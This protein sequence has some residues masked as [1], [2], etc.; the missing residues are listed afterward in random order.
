MK[1]GSF[2]NK[3]H[4]HVEKSSHGKFIKSI[5]Y[6]GLDG[7]ITTFA[8]VSG[9][10]G[11]HLDSSIVLI[12]GVANLLADGLSMGFGDY[13]SSEAE[14]EYREREKK[15]AEDVFEYHR[16][17]ELTKIKQQYQE[18]GMSKGDAEKMAQVLSN[19]KHC[20]VETFLKDRGMVKSNGSS[21][22]K[23]LYT[24]VSFIFF[25]FTP[26]FTYLMA[27]YSE[28]IAQHRFETACILTG[29]TLFGLGVAKVKV[30]KKF[31]LK[32]GL[33]MLGI[34]G[35]SAMAAYLVGHV[36]SNLAR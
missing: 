28:F 3:K 27:P 23:G 32:S 21:V 35:F 19:N 25:G 36:L 13:V 5:V 14:I 31:W 18:Q 16:E 9:V 2:R 29:A 4:D 26:L 34:G 7:I 33:E 24:F 11:A 30:T 22:R 8:I 6:G 10:S 17:Q 12:L 15:H 20:F 1:V